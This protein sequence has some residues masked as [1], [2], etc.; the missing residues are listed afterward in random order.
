MKW[1]PPAL[2]RWICFARVP[3]RETEAIDSKGIQPMA[4][5]IYFQ[6][7]NIQAQ[8]AISSAEPGAEQSPTL[9]ALPQTDTQ[10]TASIPL[11]QPVPVANS[12]AHYYSPVSIILAACA[13]VTA[14]GRA[15]KLN[16]G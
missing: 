14:I 9:P 1:H 3:H 13:L 4:V 2:Y 5:F 6:H 11:D 12:Q 7:Q 10:E 16:K 15:L 8:L